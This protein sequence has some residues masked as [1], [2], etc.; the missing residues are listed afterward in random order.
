MNAYSTRPLPASAFRFR[1]PAARRPAEG[2]A[3]K[4]RNLDLERVLIAVALAL[5]M[6]AIR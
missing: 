1:K 2:R 3:L 5:T 4:V 6:S